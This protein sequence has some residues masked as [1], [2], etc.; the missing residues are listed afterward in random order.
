LENTQPA[1]SF[2]ARIADVLR[3]IKFQHT[4]FALPFALMGGLLAAWSTGDAEWYRPLLGW[5]LIGILA[6]CVFARSAAMA[7]NRLV[8][9]EID[10]R[11]PRTANRELPSGKLSERFVRTFIVLNCIGFIASA[12]LLNRT[13]LLLS[14]VALII[15]LGYSYTKRFTWLCHLVLGLALGIAPCGAWIAITGSL[16]W[17]PVLL[18]LGVMFWTA[19]FDIIYACQDVEFDSGQDGLHSIPKKFGVGGALKISS[20]LHVIAFGFFAA[21]LLFPPLGTAYLIAASLAGMLLFYQHAII[22]ADDLSRVNVAF[23]TANG[24]L[25]VMMFAMTCVDVLLIT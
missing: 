16:A 14:P 25:S 18:G 9:R 8:D 15:L 19:G 10:A 11:N 1:T 21:M 7:F 3:M 2:S 12:G 13:A 5:P 4:L 23:F 22:S 6:C 24:I 20:A 17:P